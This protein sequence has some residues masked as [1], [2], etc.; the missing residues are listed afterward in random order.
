M[1]ELVQ[2]AEL[3]QPRRLVRLAAGGGCGW[4]WLWRGGAL[5]G[6]HPTVCPW[7]GA[8]SGSISDWATISRWSL[9][10]WR[11]GFGGL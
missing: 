10:G 7:I 6:A 3:D 1:R 4:S 5:C 2:R 8:K 9:G 11:R